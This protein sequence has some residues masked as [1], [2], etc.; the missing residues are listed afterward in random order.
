MLSRMKFEI[1]PLVVEILDQ[2]PAGIWTST[3][4]TFLDPAIGGGQFVRAIEQRLRTAGHSDANIRSRVFGFEE[5]HLHIRFAV[6]KH[7]LVGQY[8]RKPYENFFKLDNTMKFDVVVGN[9]PYQRNDGSSHK[10]WPDFVK[11]SINVIKQDG[12]VAYITPTGWF[13]KSD[14]QK[15]KPVALA[16]N[17]G[18]LISA[19]L[20]IQKIHFPMIGEDIGS[21][22]WQNAKYSGST[23]IARDNIVHYVSWNGKVI[24]L[25]QTEL[26]ILT[27]TNKIISTSVPKLKFYTDFGGDRNTVDLLANKVVSDLPTLNHTTEVFWSGSQRK[28]ALPTDIKKGWKVII[29]RSGYYYDY[30]NPTKYMLHSDS[31]GIG[32]LATGIACN[33]E[34]ECINIMTVLTSKLYVWY[35][36]A[37]KT[38][39]FNEH[40]RKLPMLRINTW[41]DTMLYQHFGL[42][43][44]EIDYVEANVK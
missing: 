21:W 35:M 4:T 37:N 36:Q 14:S 23:K 30:K 6:N 26:M 19:N 28:W 31:L 15:F 3:S 24:P 29:N 12:Y 10:L 22:I 42:T 9:P 43:Q 27:I 44:D 8:E 1:E 18:N 39:G 40:I 11:Q 2:L 13:Y 20:S 17:S 5:S 32:Q 38:N 7:N 41:T 34:Q 25:D 33:T 16:L